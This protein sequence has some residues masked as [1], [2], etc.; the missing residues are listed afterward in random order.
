MDSETAIT[1]SKIIFIGNPFMELSVG[2]IASTHTILVMV[3]TLRW[4]I[5]FIAQ[6][7]T[8]AGT[9]PSRVLYVCTNTYLIVLYCIITL[10]S[11]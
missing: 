5:Q 9:I 2:S 10:Y 8:L 7:N 11:F 3:A 6:L 1:Q 4:P